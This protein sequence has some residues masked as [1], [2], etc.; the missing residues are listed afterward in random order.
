MSDQ[1]E[2]LGSGDRPAA[3]GS[4]MASLRARREALTKRLHVDLQVPRYEDPAVFVRYRPLTQAE[5]DAAMGRH[6]KSKDPDKTATVNAALLAAACVG[7]FQVGADGRE[8]SVIVDN[9]DGEW[10]RFDERLAAELGLPDATT[11]ATVVRALYFT[12][13]DVIAAAS[14]LTAWS[15]YS[16]EKLEREHEGN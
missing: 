10:P 12:D 3:A 11:A 6:E 4:P 1:G 15:G 16:Q 8:A 5:I 7:V 9:L 14:A 2:V 13:G